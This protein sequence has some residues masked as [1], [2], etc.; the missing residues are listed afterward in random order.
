MTQRVRTRVLGAWRKTSAI[1]GRELPSR[2]KFYLSTLSPNDVW[3]GDS[4]FA[5]T[6]Q[7]SQGIKATPPRSTSSS[8][9]IPCHKKKS[10]QVSRQVNDCPLHKKTRAGPVRAALSLLLPLIQAQ[11]ARDKAESLEISWIEHYAPCLYM[12]IRAT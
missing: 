5:R 10:Y 4:H 2:N 1:F 6:H 11:H 9:V 12:A 8:E 3:R 7:R